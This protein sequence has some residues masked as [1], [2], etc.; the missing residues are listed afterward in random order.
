MTSA[1]LAALLP[2]ALQLCDRYALSDQAVGLVLLWEVLI[3]RST[4]SLL[5]AVGTWLFPLLHKVFLA[6]P[7]SF[8]TA[9][10]ETADPHRSF[11]HHY[12]TN[13]VIVVASRVMQALIVANQSSPIGSHYAHLLVQRVEYK[14]RDSNC[15]E[16][17]VQFHGGY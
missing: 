3:R 12:S 14:V 5:A 4:S 7:A 2:L 9:E 11:A 17:N 1:A 15:S 8:A 6:V 10:A 13:A 16:G